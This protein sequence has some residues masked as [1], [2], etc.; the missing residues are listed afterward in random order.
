MTPLQYLLCLVAI[1]MHWRN[2]L[3]ICVSHVYSSVE[4]LCFRLH[5]ALH[6]L[7]RFLEKRKERYHNYFL[8]V[9][10]VFLPLPLR[11]VKTKTKSDVVMLWCASWMQTR[12]LHMRQLKETTVSLKHV[13]FP[14][15]NAQVPL[16]NHQN[17]N[18][19]KDG[20]KILHL[21][22]CFLPFRKWKHICERQF[23]NVLP[24]RSIVMIVVRVKTSLSL[25]IARLLKKQKFKHRRSNGMCS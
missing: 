15:N 16:Q 3:F 17:L 9:I 20:D 8:F 19:V 13:N 6:S 1:H 10:L 2:E 14:I 23:L 21:Q 22:I 11:P 5:N 24:V 4:F 7:Q 12:N 25:S 18:L